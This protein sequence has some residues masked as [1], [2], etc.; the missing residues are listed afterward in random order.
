MGDDR[1]S[2]LAMLSIE[3][4]LSSK[5]DLN[6]VRVCPKQKWQLHISVCGSI[7]INMNSCATLGNNCTCHA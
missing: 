1:L 6:D 5:L 3:R 4:E 2:S 7:M